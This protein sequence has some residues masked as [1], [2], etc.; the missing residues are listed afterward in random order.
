MFAEIQQNKITQQIIHQIHTA[1]IR[2][3][4]APGDRLPFESDLIK[5]FGIS[6]Q[7]LRESLRALEHM[8]LIEIRKGMG[9]GSFVV[10]VDSEVTKRSL[11]NYFYFKNLSITH[12]TEVRKLIEPYAA[13]VAAQKMSDQDIRELKELNDNALRFLKKKDF[14]QTMEN[15]IG[16][17]MKLL[18]QTENP[19]LTL[20]MEFVESILID[21]KKELEMGLDFLKEVLAAHERIYLAIEARDEK[22]ASKE[23]MDHILELEEGL[24]KKQ[25]DLSL[26]EVYSQ[27]AV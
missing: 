18:E 8:G 4:L 23:M 22:R 26:K 14:D 12:L 24:Y 10:E 16:F 2:G 3:K 5:Q 7:T 25:K 20:L 27:A 6:K 19:L 17:H 1:I 21:Y 9:G 11:L 13:S 15:E